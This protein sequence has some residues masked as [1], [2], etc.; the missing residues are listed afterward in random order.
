MIRLSKS[1]IDKK[2]IFTVS[3]SL[4]KEYLGMG[5][6]VLLFENKIQKFLKTKKEVI[7]VSSGSAALHLSLHALNLSRKDEVIIP[8]ISFIAALQAILA[9]GAKPIFCDINP[10]NG[11]I[12]IKD[13]KKKI[14]KRTK[15]IM[16]VYYASDANN[17]ND[18]YKL[19]KAYKIRVVEDAA[20]AFGSILFGKNV[21]VKGD[22]ICFSFDGIKNITSGEGGA[23][24]TSDKKIIS[25]IKA[26]R[27]LGIS[28]EDERRYQNKKGFTYD[29]KVV[30]FRYHLSNIFAALG[31]SQLS[32][33]REFKL[34]RQKLVEFYVKNLN[35]K[36]IKILNLN[37]KNI[38]PHIFVIRVNSKYRDKLRRFLKK[39]KVETGVHWIPSHLFTVCKKLKIK[40]LKKSVLF[41]K[42]I[43]SL[44]LH[45]DL[46]SK[47]QKKIIK[48]IKF[49]FKCH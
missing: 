12:D 36:N 27:L 45:Y 2:D 9:V 44:P 40:N 16:P 3:K 31:I 49:F 7:C 47:E 26:S 41:S 15:V 22:I 11:F 17:I 28:K 34:K 19:A 18:V 21:G 32:K 8:S 23:I 20:N 10:E 13:L 6:D 43:I 14:T 29:V 30:G 39:N 4:E 48:L 1:S 33:A 37:Y 35:F 24:L 42:Q 5:K 25:T 38:F 46:T